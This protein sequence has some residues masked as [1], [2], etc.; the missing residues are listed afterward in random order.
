MLTF[1]FIARRGT[2]RRTETTLRSVGKLFHFGSSRVVAWQGHCWYARD[3]RGIIHWRRLRSLV[4][5]ELVLRH[6]LAH[7]L[8][9]PERVHVDVVDAKYARIL[10]ILNGTSGRRVLFA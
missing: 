4:L 7:T 9:R 1:I 10:F 6:K 3:R 8:Q 2:R 5:G